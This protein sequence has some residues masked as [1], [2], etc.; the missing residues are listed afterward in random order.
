MR[1]MEGT[2]PAFAGE[3]AEQIRDLAGFLERS[4]EGLAEQRQHLE[5]ILPAALAGE[6]Y[7]RCR[8]EQI[9]VGVT[10]SAHR[11]GGILNDAAT[12]AHDHL[13]A[14]GELHARLVLR[15]RV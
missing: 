11:L 10:S 15:G 7:G 3:Y 4:L 1:P 14:L 12:V 5:R 2:L 6:G 13:D 8:A 9:S